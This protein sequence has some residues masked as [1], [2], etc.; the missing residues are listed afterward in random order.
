MYAYEMQLPKISRSKI[1]GMQKFYETENNAD[2][3]KYF[4]IH[5]E[6]DIRHAQLWRNIIEQTNLEKEETV[7][8]AA[9]ISL[10]AQNKLLDS[11]QERYLVA[12]YH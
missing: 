10:Q 9:I 12:G 7:F 2:A 1:D 3:T 11:I 5:E 6:T 8:N 4:E